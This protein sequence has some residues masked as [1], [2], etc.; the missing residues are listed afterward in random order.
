[1]ATGKRK[2]VWSS[3]YSI[4]GEL[5]ATDDSYWGTG[6]KVNGML[7]GQGLVSDSPESSTACN[8]QHV[9]P[10]HSYGTA[11]PAQNQQSPK[12]KMAIST[13]DPGLVVW[14]MIYGVC[15]KSVA[16]DRN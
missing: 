9:R 16:N 12:N 13:H 14:D 1:M 7:R 3:Q 5:K 4:V 15:F 6:G 11:Q 8:R 10:H 2:G